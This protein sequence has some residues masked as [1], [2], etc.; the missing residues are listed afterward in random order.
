MIDPKTKAFQIYN[1]LTIMYMHYD[2]YDIGLL[3][4]VREVGFS[5]IDDEIENSQAPIF[6]SSLSEKHMYW[7][8]VKMEF[9]NFFKHLKLP[10]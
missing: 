8:Q 2:A 7:H 1:G 4:A 10:K 3:L 5:Q 6:S 9:N